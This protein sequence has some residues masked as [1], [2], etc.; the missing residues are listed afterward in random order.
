MNARKALLAA[1]ALGFAASAVA[2]THLYDM[3]TAT[4]SLEPGFVRITADSVA[5][6]GSP[7]GWTTREGLRAQA[8]AHTNRVANASRG[9]DDPPPIWTTPLTEDAVL[10]SR[11]TAFVLPPLPGGG[12]IAVVCGTSDAARD[13]H[14]DFT[15]GVGDREQRLRF[16]GGYRF[17][18]LRFEVPA[19]S[20]PL[21]VRLVPRSLWALNAVLAW[22]ADDDARVENE[23]LRRFSDEPGAWAPPD[24]WARWKRDP[25]PDPGPMPEP[26]AEDRARGFLVFARP[27]AGCVFPH[28]SPR[29]DEIPPRLRTFATPGEFEPFTF[30]VRPLR[31]LSGARVTVRGL[32]PVTPRDIDIRRVRTMPARPNYSTM[33]RWWI[34]PDVLERFESADLPAD[35]NARFWITLRVPDD[36]P[37]GVHTGTVAFSCSG[38]AAE[39]P[40]TLRI[41]PFPLREDP[42]RLFGIYYHHPYDRLPGATDEV[43]RAYFRFRAEREHA[44][45]VAHGTRNVTLSCSSP[46]ADAQGNFRFNWDLLQDK[47]D[48]WKRHGFR[49]PAVMHISAGE[50]YAKH[51]GERYGSHLRGVR[52]PPDSFAREMTA[53]VRAIEAER[54]RRGWPEFLYYPVDEPSTDPAA[55]RFMVT[56]LRACKEAGVRTYVTADRA[57]EAFAPMAPHVD[58]WCM[59]PFSVD[60][61]TVRREAARG[62]ETWCYPNHISGENNRTPVAGAR[63]TYGFGF[64]RS[65][66]RALIPW[67]YSSSIG[68]PMNYLDGSAQ[69]FLNRH[70]PDGTPVPVALWEAMRE[71]ADDYRYLHTLEQT[72][73]EARASDRPAVRAAVAEAEKELAAVEADI[74]VQPKYKHDGLW[75]P[76]EFD[77]HRWRIARQ[78]LAL[79]AALGRQRP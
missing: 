57:H 16:E 21:T 28:E 31:P 3:G 51:T 58:V 41:L 65:G 54:V 23:I 38:G 35:V 56:V 77:V 70:E 79:N 13:Q 29:P 18:V 66:Y 26:S 69:D 12:R 10:G 64:W 48:L 33:H 39:I 59:Q 30:T 8:R 71:G 1:S 72:L 46:P 68:D 17:H 25:E 60:R 11:E 37:A 27:W 44:D 78:I 5:A 61:E 42:D 50:V 62:V 45:L 73:A 53:M 75:A 32:G 4:S 20:A 63:M 22:S 67:I 24:E 52:D 15:V 14:F 55:V 9:T 43:S 7:P 49:G 34:A 47:F 74:R 2:G 36:A 40:V 6:P 19:G 76:A